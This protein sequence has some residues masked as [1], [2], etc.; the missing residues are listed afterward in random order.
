MST[1]SMTRYRFFSRRDSVQR[2]DSQT[3]ENLTS[4]SSIQIERVLDD[5]RRN[6]AI[7]CPSWAA[8]LSQPCKPIRSRSFLSNICM[9]IGLFPRC[10]RRRLVPSFSLL[11]KKRRIKSFLSEWWLPKSL[12]FF[13]SAGD[14]LT[15]KKPATAVYVMNRYMAWCTYLVISCVDDHQPSEASSRASF[16]RALMSGDIKR[17]G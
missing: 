6:P 9:S 8:G 11:G 15:I 17:V 12:P 10:Q 2:A 7:Y 13:P 14:A 1:I 3:I 4:V 5:M 16:G